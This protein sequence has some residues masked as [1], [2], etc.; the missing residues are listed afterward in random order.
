MT[1]VGAVNVRTGFFYAQFRLGQGGKYDQERWEDIHQPD[2][3]AFSQP[4]RPE[5][6]SF[7]LSTAR[8]N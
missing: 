6:G 2:L 7:I 5:G 3:K 1:P 4:Y 8:E